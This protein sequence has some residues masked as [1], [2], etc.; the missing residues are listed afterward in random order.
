[1]QSDV[2]AHARLLTS[3]NILVCIRIRPMACTQTASV[4]VVRRGR[5]VCAFLP[6]P[7]GSTLSSDPDAPDAGTR[8]GFDN[9][10]TRL[11]AM[12]NSAYALIAI[13]GLLTAILVWRCVCQIQFWKPKK[14]GGKKGGRKKHPPKE[15]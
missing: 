10:Y 11:V 1:M 9:I 12:R 15:A 6:P 13:W 2:M 5:C 8:D 3:P 14:K 4:H 7:Q